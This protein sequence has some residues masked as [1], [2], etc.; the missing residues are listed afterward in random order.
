METAGM[1]MQDMKEEYEAR[2]RS[3]HADFQQR[4]E[5]WSRENANLTERLKE[6]W[7]EIAELKEQNR[8]LTQALGDR[9]SGIGILDIRLESETREWTP[10]QMEEVRQGFPQGRGWRGGLRP[11]PH[12]ENR[13]KLDLLEIE[14]A[15][16]TREVELLKK[17][18]EES[19]ST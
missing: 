15:H 2:L 7:Q 16:L 11:S 19:S 14:I 13:R 1:K 5:S 18:V 9:Q 6:S 17:R 12:R 10:E 8:V 3:Q 4:V